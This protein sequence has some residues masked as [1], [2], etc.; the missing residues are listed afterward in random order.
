MT[1]QPVFDCAFASYS[2]STEPLSSK[3]GT[4]KRVMIR[5]LPWLSGQG[6]SHLFKLFLVWSAAVTPNPLPPKWVESYNNYRCY[7]ITAA[8]P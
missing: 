4:H 3:Y 8:S 1:Q 6:P 2:H 5:L 7:V